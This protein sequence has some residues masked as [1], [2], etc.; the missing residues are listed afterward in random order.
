[1]VENTKFTLV[2][3]ETG[4][5]LIS[6]NDM[7]TE[8]QWHSLRKLKGRQT[9]LKFLLSDPKNPVCELVIMS[10][11]PFLGP[12]FTINESYSPGDLFLEQPVGSG[13]Y[14]I[15]GRQ[16]DVLVH[17]TGE[18]TNPLP[19][20]LAIQQHPLVDHAVVLGHHHLYCSV[21]IELNSDE[22]SKH[23]QNEIEKEIFAAVQ[24]ANKDAPSHSRIAPALIKIL[25]L[26]EHLSITNKGNVIRKQVN[27]DYAFVVEQM[28]EQFLNESNLEYN[29]QNDYQQR[30]WTR[31]DISTYLQK[32][33]ATILHEPIEKFDDHSQS[34]FALSL[35]SLTVVQLRNILCN[36]FGNLDRNIIFEFPTIDD[37]ADQLLTLS[38]PAYFEKKLQSCEGPSGFH[39]TP[40]IGEN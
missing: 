1:M 7:T 3:T 20:E 25:P 5:I 2:F 39:R 8:H 15:Q 26:N 9:N 4:F 19:I 40:P 37:L 24:Y 32:T 29:M 22:A 13:Y 21:L 35:D 12:E 14:I 6:D 27:I 10:T 31:E 30:S 38:G 11:D 16:D 23:E 28:Y 36:K 33:V 34:L 18:K 17:T